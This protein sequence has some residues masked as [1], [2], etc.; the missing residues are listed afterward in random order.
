LITSFLFWTEEKRPF[1]FSFFTK[2]LEKILENERKK[3]DKVVA[4]QHQKEKNADKRNTPRSQKK[5]KDKVVNG[6]SNHG[7]DGHQDGRS[8]DMEIEVD[9]ETAEKENEESPSI[10]EQAKE[11]TVIESA[12]TKKKRKRKKSRKEKQSKCNVQ[13]QHYWV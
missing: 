2:L 8:S 1:D 10:L 13:K 7:P 9:A 4:C 6:Q 11:Q 3:K 5:R 12:V